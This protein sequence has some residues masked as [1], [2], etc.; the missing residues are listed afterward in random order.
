VQVK[1]EILWKKV[2]IGKVMRIGF[3]QNKDRDVTYNNQRAIPRD[4]PCQKVTESARLP[5]NAKIMIAEKDIQEI[6]NII[7]K[8]EAPEKIII[9]GS[10]ARGEVRP[11]D[12]DI[13]IIKQ[14][15]VPSPQR[16]RKLRKILAKQPFPKDIL[17]FTPE[18]FNRWI[19][20]PSSFNSIVRRE[21]KVIYER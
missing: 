13:L 3:Q 14:T 9:F 18:E 19:D 2:D 4:N 15:D 10:C 17:V 20:I 11:S 21:G 12:L 6:K 5:L 7:I 16:S 8:A 1:V